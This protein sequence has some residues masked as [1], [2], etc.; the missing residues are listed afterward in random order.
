MKCTNGRTAKSILGD[1]LSLRRHERCLVLCDEFCVDIGKQFWDVARTLCREAVMVVQSELRKD[2]FQTAPSVQSWIGQF[3][4]ALVFSRGNIRE[5]ELCLGGEERN[6]RIALFPNATEE[7]FFDVLAAD[8]VKLGVFTRKCAA[9]LGAAGKIR[10]KTE[11]GTDLVL[12][13]SGKAPSIRD[14][15]ISSA[16]M[17]GTFPAGMARIMVNSGSA[18]GR[19]AVKGPAMELSLVEIRDGRAKQVISSD[20]DPGLDKFIKGRQ[21]WRILTRFGVG[22]LD[23]VAFNPQNPDLRARGVVHFEFGIH[24]EQIKNPVHRFTLENADVWLDNRLWIERGDYV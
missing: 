8:W 15:R 2:D 22:T 11:D 9:L 13:S 5:V 7:N 3:D 14:G 17:V 24:N 21:S 4:T 6:T 12:D 20:N 23:T 1:C 10:V 19:L 16:G 18:Q